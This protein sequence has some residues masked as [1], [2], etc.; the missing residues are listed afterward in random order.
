MTVTLLE[1]RGRGRAQ[2]F[3]RGPRQQEDLLQE[4]LAALGAQQLRV[5]A[6]G[7]QLRGDLTM[8]YRICYQSRLASRVLWPLAA[9]PCADAE[10]LYAGAV[11]IDWG[12]L[13]VPGATLAI[14]CNGVNRALRHTRFTAQRLK[15]AIVD[16]LQAD[17]FERPQ[18]DPV[19]ADVR[20]QAVLHRDRLTLY[21]D[22]AGTA[23]H[24][25]GWR[26]DGGSAPLKENLAAALLLRAGWQPGAQDWLID[27]L[28][29]SGTLLVEG[30]LIAAGIAPG[31]LRQRFGF[32]GWQ[33]H[34]AERLAQVEAEALTQPTQP[35]RLFGR[36]LDAAQVERAH[37]HLAAAGA[38]TLFEAEID[39]ACEPMS[40]EL[41]LPTPIGLVA[42][43]PPYGQRL[44][45]ND[46]LPTLGKLL[47][48]QAGG[49]P[50]ALLVGQPGDAR[51]HGRAALEAQLRELD[52]P[53]LEALPA[54][55]G[56]LPIWMLSGRV[57][58]PQQEDTD[59][60]ALQHAEM[61][62]NRVRK[63]QQRL[64]RWA[65][66]N[67]LEAY[68]IYD[69]DL[70]EYALVVDRYADAACVQEI[71]PPASIDP[72]MA[73]RRRRAA[74]TLLPGAL[75]IEPE[76]MYFRERRRQSPETQYGVQERRRETAWV[77]EG[78][79]RFQVNLSDYLDTGL[80]L[81]SRGVR[82]LLREHFQKQPGNGR[83]LNLFA[84]T[85][86]ATVQAALG[87]AKESISVDLSGTYLDWA[88]RN[89]EANGLDPRRHRRV[90]ADVLT[91]LG[92]AAPA[93]GEFS[94]ILLD[95]PTF[96]N[97]KRHQ[98]DLDL[99]RDH[100]RLLDLARARLAPGGHLLF[101][102][103]ARQFRWQWQPPDDSWQLEEITRSTLDQ[104][105]GRGRPAHRC[106]R[107]RRQTA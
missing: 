105:C 97:S 4:E 41:R 36:D 54:R 16:R 70:P 67:G 31:R 34:D 106:W 37:T 32:H 11:A 102:T 58:A 45:R 6:G 69:R 95:A 83:F 27:P 25:R 26:R 85:C 80:Y 46:T 93:E 35:V 12:N 75:G 5:R 62:A 98:D 71:A 87:G 101:V 99:Q 15:D 81:D 42:S 24:Q 61:F 10:A 96:S 44:A 55:N 18:V 63:N 49:A 21:L 79:A 57:V 9:F 48:Q 8:A 92:D 77:S 103:H 22:L 78:D 38:G 64:G 17:G 19:A 94:A 28:C 72:V 59:T 47:R 1:P 56:A 60:E 53:Q 86:S 39:L 107:I 40:T 7:V 23:L 89:L 91:W 14:G 100:G 74:L 3:V 13:M 20:L 76:A 73:E 66:R 29:G 43:N 88:G 30:A 82:R 65:R 104:D 68:R 33:G 50:L 2:L 90:R 51:E 52:L 84:Y